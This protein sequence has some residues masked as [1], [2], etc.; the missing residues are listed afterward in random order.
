M[1]RENATRPIRRRCS[2]PSDL[3]DIYQSLPG[4][5]RVVEAME[6]NGRMEWEAEP[7]YILTGNVTFVVAPAG[8][9]IPATEFYPSLLGWSLVLEN[10]DLTDSTWWR[11]GPG[12]I[13]TNDVAFVVLDN[14][15]IVPEDETYYQRLAV[16]PSQWH[17]LGSLAEL[18]DI[19]G[20]EALSRNP[21][22][23]LYNSRATRMEWR[24]RNL[25]NQDFSTQELVQDR[26]WIFYSFPEFPQ[27]FLVAGMDATELP[28]AE[29]MR[30]RP[31]R[32]L[33]SPRDLTDLWPASYLRQY[34][35]K[36]EGSLLP[37]ALPNLDLAPEAPA[38]FGRQFELGVRS[39]ELWKIRGTNFAYAIPAR[40]AMIPAADDLDIIL[41]RGRS[42][43]GVCV[44]Y[45]KVGD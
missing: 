3:R 18:Q 39:W 9:I 31:I 2:S 24:G 1:R 6:A 44:I 21:E 19:V 11:A 17:V 42:E 36:M 22:G 27:R 14:E 41:S 38:Q 20:R 35:R 23:E 33:D 37:E 15:E 32:V 34:I 28:F 30:Y 45:F 16:L 4:W 25:S 10:L 7:G 43:G 40:A 26:T 13:E 12:F 5:P 8:E 29:G